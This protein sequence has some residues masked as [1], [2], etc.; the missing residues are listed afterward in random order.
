M[1]RLLG[2]GSRVLRVGT[3]VLAAALG[4][5]A[6]DANPAA[7][8]TVPTTTC[9]DTAQASTL[10]AALPASVA[11][12]LAA[13]TTKVT[14]W[15]AGDSTMANASTCPIGWGNK[16]GSYFNSNVT[17]VNN[18]V[19]GRSIQT[20]LYDPNVTSTK[21]SDG[22]CVISP[23]TYS[24][25]WQSMLDSST[26]MKSGDY[27]FVQFGINDGDSA[28]PR[29]VGSAR[30]Q[31]LLK[32]M[33]SAAQA[34]GVH[35][36]FLTPVAAITCSGSTAVGNRG[37][38][39]DT[40]TAAAAAGV[41]V[42]DLHA[43]SVALYNKLGLCPNN[44]DY[45]AGAVGAFFCN[46][47]THFEA[48]G[49]TQIAGVVAGALS[50]AGIGLADYL[51]TAPTTTT[52]TTTRSTTTTTTSPRTTTTSPTTSTA[53]TTRPVTTTTTSRTSTT[54]GAR[55]CTASYRS[56]GSWSG[57]FQ[58]EVTVT[59]SGSSA[60]NGWTVAM[61]FGSGQAVSQVWNGT[62]TTSGATTTVTD[63]SWNGPLAPAAATT[64]GFLANGTAV[65]PT[66]TCTAR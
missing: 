30:F 17:V 12:A 41:P 46:D 64:F 23:N 63:A 11:A 16:F 18:A 21:G 54:G 62:A 31:T 51:L 24:S 26:G 6:V 40:K 28:C 50:S 10:G 44:S 56:V 61:T 19:A 49:A 36:V 35:A 58:G 57:G 39:T 27:L 5:L 1:R 59:N 2:P 29:H 13:A 66:L 25:R 37:F 32:A 38:L 7:A 20:W 33:A 52:S 53:S 9:P 14:V 8:N 45:T 42:I 3:L 4:S 43:L 65:A 15:M 22:E 55:V 34:R 47:H 60:L 48:A